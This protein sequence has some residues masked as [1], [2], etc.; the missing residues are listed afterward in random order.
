MTVAK[1][2]S[3]RPITLVFVDQTSEENTLSLTL[4]PVA[5]PALA[6][7]SQEIPELDS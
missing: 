4:F 2:S 6:M 1:D 7:I 3:K 5:M